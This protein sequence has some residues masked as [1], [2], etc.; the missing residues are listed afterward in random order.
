MIDYSEESQTSAFIQRNTTNIR[1]LAPTLAFSVWEFNQDRALSTIAGLDDGKSFRSASVLT[2]GLVFASNGRPELEAGAVVDIINATGQPIF[3]GAYAIQ[4]GAL[5]VRYPIWL[6]D[7]DRQVA[8]VVAEFGMDALAAQNAQVASRIQ[9]IAALGSFAVLVGIIVFAWLSN[10]LLGRVAVS[11]TSV[12][13]GELD[14]HINLRSAISELQDIETALQQLRRDAQ[15]LIELK[16]QSRA[17]EQIQHMALHDALTGLGNRRYLD[18]FKRHLDERPLDAWLEILHIDLDGFK[19]VN[20]RAGHEAGDKLL[21]TTSDRL[22]AMVRTDDW[23]FRIGGD[24]FVV[25]RDRGS[26]QGSELA[27]SELASAIVSRLSQP[28]TIEDQTHSVGASVGVVTVPLQN[29]DFDKAL[30]DADIAMY[31]AK[32]AGKR[33]FVHFTPYLREATQERQRLSA[34][35]EQAIGDLELQPYYQPKVDAENFALSGAEALVRWHHPEK[36]ILGPASFLDLAKERGFLVEID[37]LLFQRVCNDITI[38]REAGLVVPKIS[39]NLSG[40]RLSDPALISD[41]KSANISPGSLSFELLET[42]YL[43]DVSEDV[44]HRLDEIRDLGVSIELDDFGSGHASMVSLLQIAPDHLK[45]DKRFVQDLAPDSQSARLVSQIVEIGKSLGIAATAEG[46]ETL[47]QAQLLYE[48]GCTTLQGYHF[49]K[50]CPAQEFCK[51]YLE[52][53]QNHAFAP[54]DADRSID[55]GRRRSG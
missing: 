9:S 8:T 12:A 26:H 50:P 14:T 31:A 1:A 29:L 39:V 35:L 6:E 17:A 3:D 16:S 4:D 47:E 46:V 19:E 15:Q 49:G 42:V 7:K 22:K 44:L 21:Q 25:I 10:R 38:W 43:D 53:D 41:L 45:I 18:D 11:I 13:E 33:G 23:V 24:E 36:G 20:D 37:K 54:L 28:C 34:S 30:G 51:E 5:F 48:L 55:L 27:P 32:A 52:R 40:P 2:D